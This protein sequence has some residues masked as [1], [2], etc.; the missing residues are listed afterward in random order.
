MVPYV[1]SK[2]CIIRY[3][4]P[5]NRI[6]LQNA[7]Y[8]FC[9]L[10]SLIRLRRKIKNINN[11]S[12]KFIMLTYNNQTFRNCFGII[13]GII[14]CHLTKVSAKIRFS[15]VFKFTSASVFLPYRAEFS[16][17]TCSCTVGKRKYHSV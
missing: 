8:K 6:C 5:N 14:Y 12:L 4:R 17:C 2:K 10:T 13:I 1:A 3:Y 7:R 16:V 11:I 9:N 15:L